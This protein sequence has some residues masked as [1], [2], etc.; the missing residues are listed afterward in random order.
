M[1]IF[2]VKCTLL[3]Y[4][5]W[6]HFILYIWLL[7]NSQLDLLILLYNILILSSRL[8]K[9]LIGNSESEQGTKWKADDFKSS[10][11][12]ISGALLTLYRFRSQQS[13]WC[14]RDWKQSTS[15]AQIDR[16][17][18]QVIYSSCCWRLIRIYLWLAVKNLDNFL[19]VKNICC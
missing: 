7:L 9:P 5:N 14:R 2:Y 12:N 6:L 1:S 13:K 19:S 8:V 18:D 4:K 11:R 16:K 15:E 10:K 17:L 3:V